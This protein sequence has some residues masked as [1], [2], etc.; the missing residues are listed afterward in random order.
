MFHQRVRIDGNPLRVEAQPPKLGLHKLQG[1][2]FVTKSTGLGHQP[3]G[4][5]QNVR[6]QLV[7]C[8]QNHLFLLGQV[9]RV[10]SIK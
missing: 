2:R 8:F 6:F 5:V 7:H 9:H 10:T 4:K 3:T 1:R